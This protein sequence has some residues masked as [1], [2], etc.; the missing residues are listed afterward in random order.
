MRNSWGQSWVYNGYIKL[1]REPEE[2]CGTDSTPMNGSRCEDFRNVVQKVC[3]MW[4]VL[5]GNVYPIGTD[6]ISGIKP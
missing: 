1:K 4:G 3:G 5:F 2:K 6:W